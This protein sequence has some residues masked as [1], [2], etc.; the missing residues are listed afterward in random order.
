MCSQIFILI[1]PLRTSAF[2]REAVKDITLAHTAPPQHIISTLTLHS[3][4]LF[5]TLFW[6]VITTPLFSTLTLLCSAN[7]FWAND[8]FMR[9]LDIKSYNNDGK[10][11]SE[12]SKN[13]G[14]FT[15]WNTTQQKE[16]RSSYD[17]MNELE[18]VMPRET[19]QAVKDKYH[20]ISPVSGT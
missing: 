4:S 19:S 11:V 18:S 17:S 14:T 8:L 16:R 5:T 13:C 1:L 15:Q 12:W 20:T 2:G 10:W 7:H 3:S 9:I 6:A